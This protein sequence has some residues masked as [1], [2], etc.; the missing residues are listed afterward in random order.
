MINK[1]KRAKSAVTRNYTN[2]EL[3]A[4]LDEAKLFKEYE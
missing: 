3:H 4:C 2:I 1:S